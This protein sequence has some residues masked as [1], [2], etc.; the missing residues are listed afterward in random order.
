MLTI[1]RKLVKHRA[2]THQGHG[3]PTHCAC[4]LTVVTDCSGKALL[5]IQEVE[6]MSC[7]R[8]WLLPGSMIAKYAELKLDLKHTKSVVFIENTAL[9]T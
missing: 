4:S 1:L 9:V 7:P 5:I 2:M 6:L 8:E 3:L